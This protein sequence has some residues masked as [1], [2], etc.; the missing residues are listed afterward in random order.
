MKWRVKDYKDHKKVFAGILKRKQD[1]CPRKVASEYAAC[2]GVPLAIMLTFAE[3]LADVDLS[4]DIKNLL[5]FFDAE[6]D[7]E[8]K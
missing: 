2:T 8:N 1:S 5:D 4:E 3:E 7:N 6:I